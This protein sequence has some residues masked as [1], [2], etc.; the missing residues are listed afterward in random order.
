MPAAGGGDQTAQS[1]PGNKPGSVSHL[2]QSLWKQLRD[3]ESNEAFYA[4]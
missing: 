1:S 3:E 4:T 2:D